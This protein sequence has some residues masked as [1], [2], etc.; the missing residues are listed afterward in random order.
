LGDRIVT[1]TLLNASLGQRIEPI[2]YWTVVGNQI[3]SGAIDKKLTEIHYAMDRRI[4]DGMLIRIS[5]I[6]TNSDLAHQ[7]QSA[8]AIEMTRAISPA[9]LARFIGSKLNK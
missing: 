4:P 7:K 9:V 2:T 1:V 6:D 5:S 3:T 8:F